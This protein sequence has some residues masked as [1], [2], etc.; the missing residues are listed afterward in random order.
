MMMVV[1]AF[2]FWAEQGAPAFWKAMTVSDQQG[3][4]AGSERHSRH[5][6]K[7]PGQCADDFLGHEFEADKVAI[8]SAAEGE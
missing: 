8:I 5:E 2:S 3:G 1:I 7:R 4:D 6:T